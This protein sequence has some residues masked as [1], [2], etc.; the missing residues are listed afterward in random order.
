M[1][2]KIDNTLPDYDGIDREYEEDVSVW[3]SINGLSSYDLAIKY[4]TKSIS[5]LKNDRNDLA[6][7]INYKD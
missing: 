5:D 1:V 3:G 7:K 6:E 4:G 2:E